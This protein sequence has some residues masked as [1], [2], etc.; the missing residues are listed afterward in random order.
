MY[1]LDN[2]DNCGQPLT[3][4]LTLAGAP[5]LAWRLPEGAGHA[6]GARPPGLH[7]VPRPQASPDRERRPDARRGHRASHADDSAR[8]QQPLDRPAGEGRRLR[9]CRRQPVRDRHR[10]G[11]R[12]GARRGRVGRVKG[13]VQVRRGIPESQPDRREGDGRRRQVG[14]GPVAVAELDARQDLET[15]GHRPRRNAGQRRVRA[16]HAPR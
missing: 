10:G 8:G 13:P 11:H 16:R 5:D 12:Q 15:V 1:A 2:V 7:Q 3:W 14:D 6:G 4:F 9:G